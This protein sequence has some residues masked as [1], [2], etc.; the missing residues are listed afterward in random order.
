[1]DEDL[2][3]CFLLAQSP[4]SEERMT[5]QIGVLFVCDTVNTGFDIALVWNPLVKEYGTCYR[6]TLSMTV[7]DFPTGNLNALAFADWCECV[8]LLLA[9][10]KDS[11]YHSIFRRYVTR[12]L[13]PVHA[14]TF[15]PN[16][17]L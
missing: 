7:A 11:Q 8:T 9:A 6:R 12:L 17:G 5:M 15:H 10:T 16:H 13:R 2:R 14:L 3:M 4:L 1:M